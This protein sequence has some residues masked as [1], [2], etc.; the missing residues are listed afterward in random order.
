M[1]N[2]QDE[3]LHTENPSAWLSQVNAWYSDGSKD[4]TKNPR[5]LSV[6]Y[7]LYVD[8]LGG[9]VPGLFTVILGGTAVVLAL[10]A[11]HAALFQGAS[12]TDQTFANIK[13]I[14]GDKDVIG[15][16][17][18]EIA[19]VVLVSAYVIGAVFFRQDPKRPDAASALLVR[20][21]TKPEQEKSLAVQSTKE[22]PGFISDSKPQLI[23]RI[24]G[25]FRPRYYVYKVRSEKST[26]SNSSGQPS[27]SSNLKPAASEASISLL[28]TLIHRIGSVLLPKRSKYTFDLDAQ[29]KGKPK[30]IH[31]IGALVRPNYYESMLG[32]DAQ[33]PYLHLRCYLAS[34]GLTHLTHLVP[35]CPR[36]E[37]TRGFR[38]KM[39]I[40]IM[41]VRL[42]ALFPW[43]SRD[44]I[45]NEAHVRLATS[46]WY[47][48]TALL[49][50]SVLV[51]IT[52][53]VAAVHLVGHP[54]S[55]TIFLPTAFALML[56]FFSAVMRLHLSYCIHYMRVREVIYVLETAHLAETIAGP[57][58]FQ[59]LLCKEE[60]SECQKC[61]PGIAA[62]KEAKPA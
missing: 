57:S 54:I 3:K 40:N 39:F 47:A 19:A 32:L 10:S 44:I 52:I 5:R 29:S 9:L 8:L 34:R 45:R 56:L 36:K 11:V 33:F 50:L 13:S 2:E 31:R 6:W 26:E 46:V 38:S 14:I 23:H 42:L 27:G 41:K 35:W 20:M 28:P 15:N 1:K 30:I 21:C 58:L 4:N 60:L 25:V 7:E 59:D 43:M 61:N 37:Q 16:L 55:S 12:T 62:K 18:W 22:P 24:D 49:F 17:H 48:V 53:A 51:L